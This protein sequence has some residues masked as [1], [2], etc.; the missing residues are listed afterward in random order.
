M[1]TFREVQLMSEMQAAR[2]TQTIAAAVVVIAVVAVGAYVGWGLIT[3]GGTTTTTTGGIT[4]TILTRHDVAIQN[5]YEPAFLNSNFAKSH[6]ITALLWKGPSQEF[7]EQLLQTGQ[8]DVCWG[9]GPTLFN[10]LMT[11]NWLASLNDSVMQTIAARVNDTIAGANMKQLDSHGNLVWIAAAIS[12]FGFTVNG[13]FLSDYNL[14]APTTWTD[15]ALPIYGSLLP[16][17]PTIAMGNAPETTSN[18][19]IY[20]IITQGMGWDTGWSTLAR[21]AGSSNIYGGSVETQAA[22]ELGQVGISMSIDYYGYLTQYKNHDCHYVVPEGQTIVNGD[23]IAIAN[24]TSHKDLAEGFLDFVLSPYG[25]SLWLDPNIRR[26]PVMREAFDQP[27]GLLAPDLYAVFNNTIKTVGIDFNDT[28]SLETNAAF[29][30]YFAS[31]LTNAHTE[32]VNCW[33][34]IVSSYYGGHLNTTEMDH[35][36]NMMGVPVTI[37]DPMTL[38]SEKFTVGYARSINSNMINNPTFLSQV[39]ARWTIA[40]KNQYNDIYNQVIAYISI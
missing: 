31:V 16:A 21:M 17:I 24:N 22:A 19:R 33:H 3:G 2:N 4:L 6:G 39:Q 37:Q 14:T 10:Q 35:F 20:E 7:W 40:A 29:I 25:Q 12:S 8:I 26:M 34:L 23:P 5:V 27:L 30:Y 11:D 28:L 32:L 15:L 36:A 18:T 1:L 38:L 13:K 9:G